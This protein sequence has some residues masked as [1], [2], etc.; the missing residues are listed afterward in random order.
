MKLKYTKKEVVGYTV[1][2]TTGIALITQ[3]SNLI[4]QGQYNTGSILTAL[5]IVLIG[6]FIVLSQKE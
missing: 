6:L 5:G 2:I 3:G 4:E 1:L